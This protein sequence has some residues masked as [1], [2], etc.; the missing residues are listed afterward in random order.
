M[1][2]KTEVPEDQEK[3]R[4]LPLQ[5]ARDC[6]PTIEGKKAYDAWMREHWRKLKQLEN[7]ARGRHTPGDWY[8]GK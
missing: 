7:E 4:K 3:R 2:K 6:I 5:D 8:T 1:A